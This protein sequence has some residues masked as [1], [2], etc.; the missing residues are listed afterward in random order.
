[1]SLTADGQSITITFGKNKKV[2]SFSGDNTPNGAAEAL[3]GAVELYIESNEFK[4]LV[5]T[6]LAN[7]TELRLDYLVH[8]VC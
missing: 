5:T 3:R 1:M 6:N 2:Y 4:E 8:T 7:N